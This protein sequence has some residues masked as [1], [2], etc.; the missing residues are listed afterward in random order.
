MK[1]GEFNQD[2]VV[3]LDTNAGAGFSAGMQ[4]RPTGDHDYTANGETHAL[5][6]ILTDTTGRHALQISGGGTRLITD[7]QGHLCLTYRG[8][9]D[10]NNS[11]QIGVYVQCS[12][13]MGQTFS[14]P[15]LVSTATTYATDLPAG[16]MSTSGR[17]GI[18]WPT[19]DDSAGGNF[20]A[21]STNGGTSFTAPIPTV[22]FTT[23]STG[24]SALFG[25]EVS[26][27][28]EG[29][30]ILWITTT[31]PTSG[32]ASSP[33]SSTRPATTA[34]AS[35]E[36]PWST[37]PPQHP[38]HA[39]PE[40]SHDLL[41][42]PDSSPS[43]TPRPRRASPPST[44]GRDPERP[45]GIDCQRPHLWVGEVRLLLGQPRESATDQA[46]RQRHLLSSTVRGDA[47]TANAGGQIP[48]TDN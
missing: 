9:L 16:A 6:D 17:V 39:A 15:L 8:D 21:V 44:W 25:G 10:G 26:A 48:R 22:G 42:A 37:G 38:Q 24:S 13:N 29:S 45:L 5:D 46:A 43:S 4:V 2:A 27:A 14:A 33:S 35:A 20:L 31:T 11:G 40:H 7:G 23:S 36:S 18:V 28:Y 3:W 19:G 32:T 34:T 47:N 12:Q 30:D 41:R 1:D